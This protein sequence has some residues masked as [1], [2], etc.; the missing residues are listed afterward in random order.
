[1]LLDNLRGQ[2]ARIEQIARRYGAEKVRVF[3]SVARGDERRDSDIDILVELPN[4]Y[5]MFRQRLPLTRELSELTGRRID[6]VPEHELNPRFAERVKR[7]A[8]AL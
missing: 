1:M 5:D 4:G 2:R 6:L 7:E 8:V 3:G